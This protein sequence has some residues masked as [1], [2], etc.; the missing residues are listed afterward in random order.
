MSSYAGAER[1]A[2]I[3]ADRLIRLG[4]V[5]F[6]QNVHRQFFSHIDI[7]F[8]NFFLWMSKQEGKFVVHYSVLREYGVMTAADLVDI[9]DKLQLLG[10]LLDE[11]FT[12]ESGVYPNYL[13]SPDAFKM[14]LMRAQRRANHP[15][16]PVIYLRHFLL[17]EK[18]LGLYRDYKVAYQEKVIAMK[19]GKIDTLLKESA[20]QTSVI[21][22][23]ASLVTAQDAKMSSLIRDT[24]DTKTELTDLHAKLN[25]L[26]DGTTKQEVHKCAAVHDEDT[27][28]H[29]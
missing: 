17:L 19:D 16:D 12:F 6:F 25:S 28:V 1:Y 8:M 13:L 27:F 14:C 5:E 9:K 10:L 22:K 18:I 23:L 21:D 26:F 15:I 3:L 29:V 2:A 11:D 7:K 4:L 20:H 24:K